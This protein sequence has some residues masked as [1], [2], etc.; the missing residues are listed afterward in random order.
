MKRIVSILVALILSMSMVCFATEA[1][2]QAYITG[3]GKMVIGIT[4]YAPMNYYDEN[5]TLIGFD[6]EFAQ[7]LCEKMGIDAEFVVIDWSTKEIELKAK[8]I[9]CIW[10]GLTVTEER[11]ENM[12]FSKSYMKNKQVVVI[13]SADAEKYADVASIATG[14]LVAEEGSAGESAILADAALSTAIYTPIANMASCLMEIKAGTADAAILD[15]TMAS[16]MVGEGTDYADLM[17]V[18][19]IELAVE[20]Y[21]IGFRVGSNMAAAA[22]TVIDELYADGTMAQLAEKY[23]LSAMLIAE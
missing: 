4:E 14:A 7:A 16:A 22:D 5:G 11:K 20:E 10:N 21:A 6:T 13:R 8:S 3:N 18:P 2:D 17:I 15:V 1:D 9:D 23:E 19:G 12:Q